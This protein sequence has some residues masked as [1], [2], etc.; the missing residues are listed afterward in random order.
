MSQMADARGFHGRGAPG[1]HLA[2]KRHPILT[3]RDLT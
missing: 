1:Q 3:R 2:C